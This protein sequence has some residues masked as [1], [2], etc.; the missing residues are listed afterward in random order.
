MAGIRQNIL[1]NLRTDLATIDG[2]GDYTN[3]IT[4]VYKYIADLKDIPVS[5]FDACAILAFD[6]DKI[7]VNE[8]GVSERTMLVGGTIYFKTSGVDTQNAGVLE[9]KCETFIE[10]LFLLDKTWTNAKASLD[11]NSK[12]AVETI[13]IMKIDPYL[14]TGF[15]DKGTIYFEIKIIYLR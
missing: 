9:I 5:K 1:D 8:W 15:E 6:D 4:T 3:T 7:L 13:E 12:R 14:L 2:T 11:A 10:D